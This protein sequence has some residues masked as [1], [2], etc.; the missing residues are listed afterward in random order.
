MRT[1]SRRIGSIAEFLGWSADV[2]GW[3]GSVRMPPSKLQGYS[4]RPRPAAMD[5]PEECPIEGL[6]VQIHIYLFPCIPAS[7]ETYDHIISL[8]EDSMYLFGHE[9]PAICQAAYNALTN[10]IGLGENMYL[11][12]V[13]VS[14]PGSLGRAPVGG[15]WVAFD[16][17]LMG[18]EPPTSPAGIA[19]H[20]GI[21][22]DGHL[23]GDVMGYDFNTYSV[24][25][26]N[27][28]VNMTPTF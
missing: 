28:S 6:Y 13:D 21:H 10:V 7:Q 9:V 11:Y 16:M 2:H 1:I 23:H 25:C 17:R 3:G 8:V 27:G 5:D 12:N 4:P 24:P 14:Y 15:D 19:K 22:L 26:I 18:S 20:E